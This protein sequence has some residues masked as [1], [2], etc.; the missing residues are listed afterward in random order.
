MKKIFI[1]LICVFMLIGCGNVETV[2]SED[3]PE[4]PIV[5]KT[6][7]RTNSPDLVDDCYFEYIEVDKHLYLVFRAAGGHSGGITHS[8]TCPCNNSNKVEEK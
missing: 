8:G 1:G 3:V 6:A 4:S 7:V 2:K 5:V